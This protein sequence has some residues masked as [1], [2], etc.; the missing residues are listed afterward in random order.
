MNGENMETKKRR[1]CRYCKKDISRMHPA[2]KM[3]GDDLCKE[4]ARIFR[5]YQYYKAKMNKWGIQ[6]D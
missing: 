4:K 5:T 1:Q 3:C 2:S 6:N